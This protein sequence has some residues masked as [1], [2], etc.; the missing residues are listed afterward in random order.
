MKTHC[1]ETLIKRPLLLIIPLILAFGCSDEQLVSDS[2]VSTEIDLN[3][4]EDG[5]DLIGSCT[6]CTYVVPAGTVIIDAA[7]L[8]LQ[9]GSVIGLDA[10][11][12]YGNLLFRNLD[13]TYD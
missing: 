4:A 2:L 9:P 1:V 11:I 10:R 7:K 6:S 12:D 13:G 5:A 3:S 8:G